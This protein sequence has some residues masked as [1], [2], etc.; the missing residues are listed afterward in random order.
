MGTIGPLASGEYEYTANSLGTE[1]FNYMI[2]DGD[3]DTDMAT[4]T[5]NV[6]ARECEEQLS[7]N[8]ASQK[9]YSDLGIRSVAHRDTSAMCVG[10]PS[11]IIVPLSRCGF[12]Q[13]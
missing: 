1:I 3:E 11:W 2:E 9:R 8:T 12:P 6:Q 13:K 4:L 10:E 7:A 5:I